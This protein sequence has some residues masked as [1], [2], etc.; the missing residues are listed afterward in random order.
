MIR[1]GFRFPSHENSEGDSTLPPGIEVF[2]GKYKLLIRNE[3]DT[4]KFADS[5]FCM[6]LSSGQSK[7]ESVAYEKKLTTVNAF[8]KTVKRAFNSFEN[9][10]T[11]E[12]N[13]KKLDLLSYESDSTKKAMMKISKTLLDK[14]DTLKLQFMLPKDYRYYEDAT[15]RLNDVLYQAWEYLQGN[16]NITENA[17]VAINIASQFTERIEN[18]TEDFLSNLY[19]PVITAL[20][21]EGQSVRWFKPLRK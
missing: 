15:L 19:L 1:D 12:S 13:L 18:Q 20:E 3:G 9:L 11:A 6:V 5:S 17:L 7:P 16:P 10:K 8:A 4:L 21:K 2:P 14:I